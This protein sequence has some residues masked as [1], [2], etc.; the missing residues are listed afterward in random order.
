MSYS[1]PHLNLLELLSSLQ[2]RFI[3]VNS[4]S[5]SFAMTGW[6]LVTLQVLLL[7]KGKKIQSHSSSCL[8]PFI[9]EAA[10]FAA[11]QGKSLMQEN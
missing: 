4:F 8:P 5:K 7:M 6:R 9:E 11:D 10:V 1:G 3:H 2:D